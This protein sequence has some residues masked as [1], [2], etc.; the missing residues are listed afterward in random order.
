MKLMLNVG[1]PKGSK[2]GLGRTWPALPGND[3]DH[4][5]FEIFRFNPDSANGPT[6]DT[7]RLDLTGSH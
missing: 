1:L 4:R 7:Y 5:A 3:R 6:L 2:I